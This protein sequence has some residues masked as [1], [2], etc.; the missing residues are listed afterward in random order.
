V[1]CRGADHRA[2]VH[3][4]HVLVAVSQHSWLLGCD[5]VFLLPVSHALV[6]LTCNFLI[7]FCFSFSVFFPPQLTFLSPQFH[8]LQPAPAVSNISATPGGGG[9]VLGRSSFSQVSLARLGE[10]ASLLWMGFFLGNEV[11]YR[12]LHSRRLANES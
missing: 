4:G 9:G 10:G 11:P 1:C 7:Y 8:F 6:L 5:P 12:T 3:F 2:R